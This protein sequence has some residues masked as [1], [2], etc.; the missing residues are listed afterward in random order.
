[1][2]T[3]NGNGNCSQFR[4]A[5]WQWRLPQS[6]PGERYE[7]QKKIN[8]ILYETISVIR[9]FTKTTTTT[10]TSRIKEEGKQTKLSE[11]AVNRLCV[12]EKR[13]SYANDM[14][15]KISASCCCNPTQNQF[16]WNA[17]TV[18]TTLP[19]PLQWKSPQIS[20]KRCSYSSRKR[21]LCR[22]TT[23]RMSNAWIP[24]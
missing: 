9:A 16:N 11:I 10:T 22:W 15:I 18:C 7:L 21:K 5:N 19:V 3:G 1:M 8:Y 20:P 23:R 17:N 6:G 24:K 13:T 12:R 4:A 2:A 14:R